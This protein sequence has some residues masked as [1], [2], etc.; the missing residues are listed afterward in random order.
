MPISAV[1]RRL[2]GGCVW[3]VVLNGCKEFDASNKK[4]KTYKTDGAGNA[5][6]EKGLKVSGTRRRMI[7]KHKRPALHS[8]NCVTR[9]W[10]A[11]EFSFRSQ[12]RRGLEHLVAGGAPLALRGHAADSSDIGQSR[13]ISR[14]R[15][16]LERGEH[17]HGCC[18]TS[19]LQ[20]SCGIASEA[21]T[22]RKAR[23][24]KVRKFTRTSRGK[25]PEKQRFPR[26]FNQGQSLILIF[27]PVIRKTSPAGRHLRSRSTAA[28]SLKAHPPGL[29]PQTA[30]HPRWTPAAHWWA[31]PPSRLCSAA[32][33]RHAHVTRHDARA[34]RR[35][36]DAS[37]S[38]TATRA[39]ARSTLH[40]CCRRWRE[41]SPRCVRLS[42]SPVTQSER[43]AGSLELAPRRANAALAGPARAPSSIFS[44]RSHRRS[45]RTAP[46]LLPLKS[47][48]S[49][50]TAFSVPVR[51][52][53]RAR[54]SRPRT[55][56]CETLPTSG[57]RAS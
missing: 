34:R 32:R 36:S 57:I 3:Q 41:A 11:A 19:G 29:P 51:A 45:M 18:T 48:S 7:A 55:R 33:E 21:R 25:L 12:F 31:L 47:L 8:Q 15:S 43:L 49:S 56:S 46:S 30:N 42:P 24:T 26:N 13:P 52:T 35:N 16:V 39:T 28:H 50:P 23:F 38:S 2:S 27:Q 53:S 54:M 44:S 10:T 4:C 5:S 6:P 20:S 14:K 1:E 17:V 37:C 22:T 9:A 40:R